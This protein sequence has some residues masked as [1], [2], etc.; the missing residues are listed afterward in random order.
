MTASGPTA[1]GWGCHAPLHRGHPCPL[2]RPGCFETSNR[3]ISLWLYLEHLNFCSVIFLCVAK[4]NSEDFW[5]SVRPQRAP[6][7][8]S[9]GRR[10]SLAGSS[11]LGLFHYRSCQLQVQR[12]LHTHTDTHWVPKNIQK[13]FSKYT[14]MLCEIL[15]RSFDIINFVQFFKKDM[16]KSVFFY[17]IRLSVRFICA[18]CFRMTPW[19]FF[20][21]QR[22]LTK[23]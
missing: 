15:R 23:T 1:D 16:N 19:D 17:I 18:E 8:A 2:P 14:G 9:D 13:S 21:G 11:A 22:R 6:S 20:L 12:K 10:L 7:T 4:K 5:F 3:G